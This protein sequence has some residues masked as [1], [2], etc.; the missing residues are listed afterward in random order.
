MFPDYAARGRAF[1]DAVADLVAAEHG[2][3]MNLAPP[4]PRFGRP[5]ADPEARERERVERDA[6]TANQDAGQGPDPGAPAR[7]PRSPTT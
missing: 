3:P 4:I 2:G 1:K 6:R 7:A 5:V